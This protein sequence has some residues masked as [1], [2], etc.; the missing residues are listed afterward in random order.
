MQEAIKSALTR[1]CYIEKEQ[2]YLM[3]CRVKKEVLYGK[4]KECMA[5]GRPWRVSC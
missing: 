4:L 1:L 2:N 5:E 3:L